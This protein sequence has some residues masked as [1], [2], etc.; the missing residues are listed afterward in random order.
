MRLN[1]L[2]CY[3]SWPSRVELLSI[4]LNT[5]PPKSVNHH[6]GGWSQNFIKK[7][8]IVAISDLF[9][10]FNTILRRYKNASFKKPPIL[11]IP[12]FPVFNSLMAVSPNPR[13]THMAH[14]VEWSPSNRKSAARCS[15]DHSTMCHPHHFSSPLNWRPWSFSMFAWTLQVNINDLWPNNCPCSS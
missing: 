6:F 13:L 14:P 11:Q 8:E 7:G 4:G 3:F 2:Y 9:W 1:R 15:F 10:S 12:Q 5:P